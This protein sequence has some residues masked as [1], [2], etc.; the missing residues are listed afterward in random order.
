MNRNLNPAKIVVT[1][2]ALTILVGALMLSLPAA[3]VSGHLHFLDALFMATSAVCVTGLSVMDIGSELTFFGQIVLLTLIQVGG[4]SIMAFAVFFIRAVKHRLSLLSKLSVGLNPYYKDKRSILNVVAVVFVMVITFEVIG[5]IL[6]Y[7]KFRHLYTPSQALFYS[8]FHSVSAFCNAGFSLYPD[9]LIRFQHEMYLP[10]VM[11][12]LIVTGGLG[13]ML[14]DEIRAWVIARCRREPFRLSLHTKICLIG[15][16][17]LI[18]TGALIIWLLENE[19]LLLGQSLN[20]KLTNSFFLSITSRTAGFNTLETDALTN[21][22]LFFT[23][24]LMVI[25]GCPGSAAGGMKVS[26]VAI[27][28]ALI[29][30]NMKGRT[31]PS[32]LKRKIPPDTVSRALVILVATF[33]IVNVA[34]LLFQISEHRGVSHMMARGTFLDLFFESVSAFGTVGLSTGLTPV[35]S[36]WGKAISIFLMFTGRVGPSTL[37]YAFLMRSRQPAFE[38]VEEEIAVG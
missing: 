1:S 10:I 8:W 36:G 18:I 35:L 6:L 9:S 33:V 11:M 13:F 16:V 15:T 26:T 34:A 12:G 2:F 24:L 14:I 30:S 23:M 37:G 17:L 7:L 32:I 3:S 4:I 20:D 31:S 28:L 27:L 19:N 21:A 25:G 29:R 38:Y 22:T 5:T